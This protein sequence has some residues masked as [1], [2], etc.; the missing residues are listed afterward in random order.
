[1]T[2]TPLEERVLG[3]LREHRTPVSRYVLAIEVM[4]PATV[5]QSALARLRRGGLADVELGP[6]N[7]PIYRAVKGVHHGR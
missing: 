2:L 3:K 4:E 5:V 7:A 1:M 6:R